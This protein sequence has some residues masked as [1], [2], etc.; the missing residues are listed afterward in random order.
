MP[1]AVDEEVA[2]VLPVGTPPRGPTGEVHPVGR[3]GRAGRRLEELVVPVVDEGAPEHEHPLD[4][5]C[6]RRHVSPRRRTCSS[7]GK[8]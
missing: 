5:R 7:S 1:E 8:A 3:V 2:Y 4:G 6:R